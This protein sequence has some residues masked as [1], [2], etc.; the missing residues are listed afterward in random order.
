[1]GPEPPVISWEVSSVDISDQ[2]YFK[3]HLKSGRNQSDIILSM[4][5]TTM[6]LYPLWSRK[7]GKPVLD[8]SQAPR[9]VG[10]PYIFVKGRKELGFR[11]SFLAF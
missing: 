4:D 3:G 11:K 1:M 2:Y 5:Q 7:T 9:A 8:V 6:H 10:V